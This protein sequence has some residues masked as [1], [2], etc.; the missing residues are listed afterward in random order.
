[1]WA[2]ARKLAFEGHLGRLTAGDA[3]GF[4]ENYRETRQLPPAGSLLAAALTVKRGLRRP[5]LPAARLSVWGRQAPACAP[6]A[7]YKV[8]ASS[9]AAVIA[10]RSGATSNPWGGP[11]TVLGCLRADG[12]ERVLAQLPPGNQDDVEAVKQAVLA[13]PFAALVIDESD[14]HYGGDSDTLQ[15]FDLRAGSQHLGGERVGCSFN[16][17]LQPVLGSDGVSAALTS[18]PEP[19]VPRIMRQIACAPTGAPCV[20]VDENG[21]LLSS[22]NPTAG[23]GAWTTTDLAPG[24]VSCPSVTLCVAAGMSTVYTTSDPTGGA[25][26]W[27]PALLG[28]GLALA[29]ITCPAVTLCVATGGGLA[30]SIAVSSDPAGG[31]AAWTVASQGANYLGAA[32]CSSTTQCSITDSHGNVYTSSNPAGGAGA[33]TLNP[34][35]PALVGEACPSAGRCVGLIGG[36]SPSSTILTTSDPSAGPWSITTIPGDLLSIACPSSSL[37][38]A[39]GWGGALDYT[40]NP[41]DGAWTQTTIDGGRTLASIDCPSS[42]LCLAVDYSGNVL[43][44]SNPT[45]GPSAWTA[46]FID[47]N[48]C[49]AITTCVAQTIQTSDSTGLHTIDSGE[50]ATGTAGLGGL[51]LAGDTLSWTNNGTPQTA[52]LNP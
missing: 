27:T 48:P 40:T 24:G 12:R 6:P 43:T 8:N 10:T 22:N 26:A 18:A 51:T 32:V 16:C 19:L 20:A 33:W 49:R 15:V 2:I 46:T 52:S 42:S 31:V 29:N 17:S 50:F 1:M 35:F 3:L 14:P 37:C 9:S 21:E 5:T 25:A 13:A 38:L 11:T 45:G 39:A 4:F 30:G 36:G 47:G 23:A 34:S 41:T 7:G 44:T 28:A